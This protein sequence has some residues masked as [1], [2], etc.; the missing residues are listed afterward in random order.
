M[1][2]KDIDGQSKIDLKKL[3]SGAYIAQFSDNQTKK[4][5]MQNLILR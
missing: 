5:K 1:D 2:Q 4:V 3:A